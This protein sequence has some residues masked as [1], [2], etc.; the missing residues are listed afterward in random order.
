MS[1]EN[2]KYVFVTILGRPNA[3][4]STLMNAFVGKYRYNSSKTTNYKK[5][6]ERNFY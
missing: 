5:I 1:N 3:G 6:Y 2:F 4:K